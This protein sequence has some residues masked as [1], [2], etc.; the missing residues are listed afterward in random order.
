[1]GGESNLIQLYEKPSCG[2]CLASKRHMDRLGI[3]YE[4]KS[5]IEHQDYLKSLGY[6]QAPV[7]VT[8]SDHWSGYQPN[9]IDDL[10]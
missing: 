7:I 8:E 6:M 2:G 3:K 5:A 9:K 10:A 1:M 4:T